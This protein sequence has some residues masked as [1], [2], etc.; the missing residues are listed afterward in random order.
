L[1]RYSANFDSQDTFHFLSSGKVGGG[2][3]VG[4]A[5]ALAAGAAG[6]MGAGESSCEAAVGGFF[7]IRFLAGV[8]T[9]TG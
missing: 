9:R 5:G 1:F 7:F 3:L 4:A 2:A 6:E 8:A